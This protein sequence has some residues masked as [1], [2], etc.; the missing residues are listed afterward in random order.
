[1][2]A[3]SRPLIVFFALI[4]V[5]GIAYYLLSLA[6]SQPEPNSP[7]E[8]MFLVLSMIFLQANVA[9]PDHWYLQIFFFVM[10]V[11]GL[12]WLSAGAANLGVKLFNRSARGQ[13]WEVALASMYSDHVI[14]CGVG[15]LG[16]RVILQLLKFG[17]NVVAV[18]QDEKKPFISLVRQLD[19][20]VIFG[21]ARQRDIQNKA[22][23]PQAAAVV[24]CTQDDLTNLDIALDA[25]ELNTNIKV[26]LRMFD[27]DLAAKIERGFGIHTAFSASGIA[28]PAFAAAA[29]RAH[30]EYSFYVGDTLLHVSQIT[31]EADSPLVGLTMEDAE[32]R[33]EMTII[34]HHSGDHMHLHPNYDELIHAND[35]L[36]VFATLET[37][38]KIGGNGNHRNSSQPSLLRRVFKRP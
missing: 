12:A 22:G 35:T 30:I 38:G 6:S 11:I 18:E 20:P 4:I 25:R 16:Y 5:A 21:D 32:R 23:L 31:V 14:V 1:V 7:I 19:V 27:A 36:V 3:F 10:P 13:E 8:G 2:R 24:C 33:F 28:A 9:F 15:K 29:T 34:M 37:L 26:V 17:Q